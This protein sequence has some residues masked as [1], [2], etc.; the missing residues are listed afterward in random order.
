MPYFPAVHSCGENAGMNI[1]LPIPDPIY[2][3]Q[4]CRITIQQIGWS[5]ETQKEKG[6]GLY[7]RSDDWSASTFWY[8]PVPSGRLPEMPGVAARTANIWKE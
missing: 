4:E 1:C 8:E 3:K 2:W 5:R 6:S 7:E